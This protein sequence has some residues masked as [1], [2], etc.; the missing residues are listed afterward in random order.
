VLGGA[1][2]RWPIGSFGGRPLGPVIGVAAVASYE[3]AYALVR[4]FGETGVDGQASA[5]NGGRAN[6]RQ[7]D[8][9]A[10]LGATE[11]SAAGAVALL[12]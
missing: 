2:R 8:G 11:G 12:A 9:D 4:A 1:R 10:R 7:F 6:L 5:A 3:H